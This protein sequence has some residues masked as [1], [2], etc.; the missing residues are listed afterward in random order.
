[1]RLPSSILNALCSC[2]LRSGERGF[3]GGRGGPFVE[4]LALERGLGL[5]RAPGHGGDAA[6]RD[7]RLADR[8]AVEVERDRGGR[9]R[10]LVGFAVAD[11]Q[12]TASGGRTAS[13]ARGTR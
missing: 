4:R 7:P 2:G 3:G 11:F 12:V 9:Q 13:P 8:A 5:A 6:E 10:E 1:M